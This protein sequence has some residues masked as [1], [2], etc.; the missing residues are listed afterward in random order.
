MILF[1]F[2][3]SNLDAANSSNMEKHI[4][5]QKSM[6]QTSQNTS[7]PVSKSQ[8]IDLTNSTVSSTNSSN[9]L[10]YSKTSPFS[11]PRMSPSYHTTHLSVSSLNHSSGSLNQ[12]VSSS[13]P[14]YSYSMPYSQSVS[15]SQSAHPNV[16]VNSG[17]SSYPVIYTSQA[18]PSH[19]VYSSNV[20][21]S[22]YIKAEANS[23]RNV[24]VLDD[25]K[26]PVTYKISR[27]MTTHDPQHAPIASSNVNNG[28]KAIGS[29]SSSPMSYVKNAT[30]FDNSS[31]GSSSAPIDYKPPATSTADHNPAFNNIATICGSNTLTYSNMQPVDA[32]I[33]SSL[34]GPSFK[35][36]QYSNV[37]QATPSGFSNV[38]ASS[39]NLTSDSATVGPYGFSKTS[40]VLPNSVSG[41]TVDD[42]S[43][44]V[45]AIVSNGMP[46]NVS[47]ASS[48]KIMIDGAANGSTRVFPN[49][50]SVKLDTTNNKGELDYSFTSYG[51]SYNNQTSAQYSQA[52]YN[53]FSS[54]QFSN[55]YLSSYHIN[56]ISSASTNS[57][58]YLLPDHMN[59]SQG[60]VYYSSATDPTIN[61]LSKFI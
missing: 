11:S 31:Y 36:S 34:T 18:A 38:A 9:Q 28:S 41:S 47:T 21:G 44:G 6:N 50:S 30:N 40:E 25:S 7:A 14:S 35:Q 56:D 10:P 61:G 46:M 13:T 48:S 15:Y 59:N 33:N 39:I 42:K 52:G 23:N 57:N 55:S 5:H 27:N 58:G 51:P 3:V 8:T 19:S 32:S 49:Q 43:C 54:N 20:S 53:N 37:S 26:G 2:S 22:S 60:T 45:K 4:N 1:T 24:Q 17:N 16:N 12:N 29:R